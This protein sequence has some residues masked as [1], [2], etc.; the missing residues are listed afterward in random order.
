[1][2]D[3]RVNQRQAERR[4]AAW[5]KLWTW[6]NSYYLLTI[7]FVPC[8]FSRSPWAG[9]LGLSRIGNSPK[10]AQLE[11]GRTGRE[12]SMAGARAVL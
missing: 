9:E 8:V 4:R 3:L 11:D 2:A 1:M 6:N 12:C 7:C 5:T 10:T